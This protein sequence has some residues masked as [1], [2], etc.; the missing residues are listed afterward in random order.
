MPRAHTSNPSFFGC[1]DWDCNLK[2]AFGK[3]FVDPVVKIPNTHTHTHTHAHA[4]ART[5]LGKCRLQRKAHERLSSPA[6]KVL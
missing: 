3:Q 6:G 1:R 4:H 2:P 5:L